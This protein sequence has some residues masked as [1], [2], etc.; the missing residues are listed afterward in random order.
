MTEVLVTSESQQV[1][2]LTGCLFL[3]QEL[4]VLE[5]TILKLFLKYYL[6]NQ[7]Y[8]KQLDKLEI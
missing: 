2:N 1:Q 6:H 5:S 7:F 8:E 3:A 4:R